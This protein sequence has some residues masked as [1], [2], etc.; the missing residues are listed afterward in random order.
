MGGSRGDGGDTV[1]PDRPCPACRGT[2]KSGADENGEP[3]ARW[4]CAGTGRVKPRAKLI[5]SVC[6]ERVRGGLG[7]VATA[8]GD[9]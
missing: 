4:T 2:G 7:V 9:R 3:L 5:T 8:G 1:K 6:D